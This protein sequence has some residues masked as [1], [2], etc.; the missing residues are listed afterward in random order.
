MKI[1]ENI[2]GFTG[3]TGY[4]P[5]R[6]RL[7]HWLGVSVFA[8]AVLGPLLALVIEFGQSVCAGH[9]DWLK[10]ALP[11]GRRAVLLLRSL[12]LAALVAAGG[13]VLGVLAASVLWRWRSGALGCLRWLVLLA[14]VPPYIHAL[15]WSSA[16]LALNALLSNAGLP[17]IAVEG[18]A[19]SWWVQL[20]S[21]APLAAG[22]ALVGLESVD[23]TLI[24]AARLV[25]ADFEVFK[26][27]VLPLAAPVILAGGGLLFLL[28]LTDYSVPSLFS[29]NVYALEIF[30]EFSATNEPARA[31]LVS[32][33]LLVVAAF[34]VGASQSAFRNAAL[35]RPRQ[36]AAWAVLRT[37]PGWLAWLQRLALAVL[38]LQVLVPLV[39]LT[40]TAGTG[41]AVIPSI[42]A[43]KREI[44]YSFWVALLS[45][46]LYLPPALSVAHELARSGRRGWWA[47]PL[48]TV[49]LAVPPP[50]VGI[51]L[52]VVGGKSFF[53]CVYGSGWMLVLAA[54]SR[55]APLAAIVLLAYSRRIDPLL[56]DAARILGGDSLTTWVRVRLP[57]LAPGLLASASLCFALTVGEL[58]ATL[59]VAPPGLAT[60]TMRIYNY[61]HYGASDQVA[62]LCLVMSAVAAGAGLTIV[63][64]LAFWSRLFQRGA[65]EGEV[66]GG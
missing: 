6:E 31:L 20:M 29:V 27:V 25:R 39:G 37:W 33:P 66:S 38:A 65:G 43:A 28:S 40:A 11:T 16:A 35:V 54:V 9:G 13:M 44:A 56:V 7:G 26:E 64:T 4:W 61:L 10:L 62:G 41:K 19:V 3:Q 57:L 12:G 36:S 63:Y 50:L 30:A 22:P 32:A 59:V 55:F 51:G 24:E 53:P 17:G 46:G 5:G 60:L 2:K 15:A 21:L 45:A 1:L 47:W 52:I 49:P 23:P 14:P 8:A 48:V 58:G 18:P 42:A 34:V